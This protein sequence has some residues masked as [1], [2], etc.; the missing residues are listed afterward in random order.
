[1]RIADVP[2]FPRTQICA[3]AVETGW[4]EEIQAIYDEMS[5]DLV[6]AQLTEDSDRLSE[7][8]GNWGQ[9]PLAI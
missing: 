1:M 8:A 5:R 2:E 4:A 7:I 3:E 9:R 6:R